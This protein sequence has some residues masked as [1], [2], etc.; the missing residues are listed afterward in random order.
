MKSSSFSNFTEKSYQKLDDYQFKTH[1]S[2]EQHIGV[3]PLLE[4]NTSWFIAADFD[5]KK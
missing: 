1:F 5:G 3:Y 2:G 4:D